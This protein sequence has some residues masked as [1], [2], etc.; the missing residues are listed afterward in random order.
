MITGVML[1]CGA[2]AV[3]SALGIGWIGSRLPLLL[4][5]QHFVFCAEVKRADL[6]VE[7]EAT[8]L[9]VRKKLGIELASIYSLDA[10][11]KAA[12]SKAA[13]FRECPGKLIKKMPQLIALK[14]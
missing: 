4:G 8:A 1:G 14:G 2:G 7:I 6:P 13:R 3:I 12:T 10:H 11:A 5:E 9:S